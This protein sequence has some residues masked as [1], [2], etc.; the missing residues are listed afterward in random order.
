V[1][2]VLSFCDRLS[3]SPFVDRIWRSRSD[4][5]G[6]FVS[7][8]QSQFEIA[9]TRHQGRMFVTLRGPETA[10][11]VAECPADGEW[12][13]IR[14]THGTFMPRLPPG[15]LRDRHDVTLPDATT[16]SFWL[17]G[18]AWEYPDFENADT[19]VARLARKGIIARDF[20]IG[21]MLEPR[22]PTLPIR[23]VQRHFLRSTGITRRTLRRI[24]R[25]RHAALLLQQGAG[26]LDTVYDGG[27]VD[28]P[29]LTRDMKML[30]GATPREIARGAHQLSFLYNTPPLPPLY[31]A[32]GRDVHDRNGADHSGG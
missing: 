20:A 1:A 26:I 23:T 10:A 6:P 8:A 2:P 15:G 30:I 5:G 14:F 27:Y 4:R 18:S 24:E 17:D 7:I 32:R 28:Q 9:V 31:D 11:T 3:D 19:F 22:P 29:H 21:A 16:R 25:A 12:L 13:G